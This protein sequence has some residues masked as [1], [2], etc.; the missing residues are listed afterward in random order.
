MNKLAYGALW[1]FVFAISSEPT[2]RGFGILITGITG[3]PALGLALLAF[4]VSG[5]LRRWHL[6]H[7]A[8]LLFL[9]WIVIGLVFVYNRWIEIPNKFWTYIQLFLVLWMIWELAATRS[10]QIGLM[11]AYLLGAYIAAIDT[12]ILYRRQ[13]EVLRRFAAGGVD[14]NDLAMM[15]ALGIP[16]A[17]YLATTYRQPLRRWICSAYLPIALFAIGLTGSRGGMITTMICLLIVPLT[18]IRLS[19]TRRA[20]AIILM[21]LSGAVAVTYIPETLIERLASTRMEVEGGRL[22]GRWK[23]WNAGFR[24]F[25][26]KP[27]AGYGPG[28][29]KKAIDPLLIA[30]SQV[31]HNS[32]LSVLVEQ[33][34]VGLLLFSTMFFT[35]LLGI[36]KLP[37]A[38]RRFA[39]VLFVALGMSMM[40]LSSEENKRVWFMLALLLGLTQARFVGAGGILSR[41]PHGRAPLPAAAGARRREPLT[42]PV[43]T[44]DRNASA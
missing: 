12:I 18:M 39:L 3:P 36:L 32:F 2:F 35:I 23:L 17:W 37:P 13:A 27:V 19:P 21:C 16:I 30:R 44:I 43:R 10:R 11:V 24:A 38:E 14:N 29:F 15:L 34:I 26:L 8:A 5:R 20:A 7:V 42:A 31:A 4:G 25:M 1:L 6:F 9:I 22:G 40:P 33:G 41:T 28:Q